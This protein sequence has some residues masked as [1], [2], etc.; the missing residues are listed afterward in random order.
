METDRNFLPASR[1]AHQGDDTSTRH[2]KQGIVR[3]IARC[4]SNV[5]RQE[6]PPTY[7]TLSHTAILHHEISLNAKSLYSIAD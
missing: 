7:T 3:L 2:I 6:M 1:T 4:R 5:S